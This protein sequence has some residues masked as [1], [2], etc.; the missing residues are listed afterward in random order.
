MT[1]TK[2]QPVIDT[3]QITARV[4]TQYPAGFTAKCQYREKKVLGDLFNLNQFGVNL[5]RQIK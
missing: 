1:K 4:G 2:Q 3:A 5:T